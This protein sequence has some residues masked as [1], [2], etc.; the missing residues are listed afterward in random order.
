MKASGS[1]KQHLTRCSHPR[2][3]SACL[4]LMQT[5]PLSSSCTRCL[6]L[7]ILGQHIHWVA[8]KQS[9][10]AQLLSCAPC[11][12]FQLCFTAA[13]RVTTMGTRVTSAVSITSYH[14]LPRSSQ[15]T[16]HLGSLLAAAQIAHI[17]QKF[18]SVFAAVQR[19]ESET[20]MKFRGVS[21]RHP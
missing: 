11:C 7:V 9:W 8:L 19:C 15:V 17:E 18:L 13:N 20:S 4:P 1:A 5:A 21:L 6:S 16:G 14:H 3:P 2:C 12:R 10:D